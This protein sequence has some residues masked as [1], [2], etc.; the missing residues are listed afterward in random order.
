MNSKQ[1][2]VNG[3]SEQITIGTRKLKDGKNRFNYHSR[4]SNNEKDAMK[5]NVFLTKLTYRLVSDKEIDK[6]NPKPCIKLGF[7]LYKDIWNKYYTEAILKYGK[8]DFVHVTSLH[9]W[10]KSEESETMCAAIR[11]YSGIEI[12]DNMKDWRMEFEDVHAL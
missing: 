12:V 8:Y 4:Y 7:G 11:F 3:N 1:M 2:M 10:R 6:D 5:K 9:R